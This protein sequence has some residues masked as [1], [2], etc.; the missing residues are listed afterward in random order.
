MKSIL[1]I[2]GFCIIL[3]SQLFAQGPFVGPLYSKSTTWLFSKYVSD[4]GPGMDYAISGGQ[5]FGIYGGYDVSE[6]FGVQLEMLINKHVQNYRG[7]DYGISYDSKVD[8]RSFDLPILIKLGS[9]VYFEM[10]PV[11]SFLT[12]GTYTLDVN[13]YNFMDTTFSVKSDYKTNIGLAIGFGGDIKLADNLF[14]NLGLRVTPGLVNLGGV[15][16]WGRN[17]SDLEFAKDEKAK[18]LK[19]SS[20][21]GAVHIGVKY[22]IE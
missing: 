1:S 11:F 16:A 17:K 2:F 4:Q 12:K 10:G 6:S 14:I 15:D 22:K 19:T 21:A 5:S 9:P 8:L 18:N 20:L 7:D 3:S 13:T